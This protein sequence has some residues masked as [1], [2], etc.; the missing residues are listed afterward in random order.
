M[1][2]SVQEIFQIFK[3]KDVVA[4]HLLLCDDV[5]E[6]LVY[7]VETKEKLG[8]YA[9][10]LN[11]YENIVCDEF[12]KYGSWFG[13]DET[14]DEHL[15]SLKHRTHKIKRIVLESY[16]VK[17]ARILTEAPNRIVV[18]VDGP[19]NIEVFEHFLSNLMKVEEIRVE[20]SYYQSE[21][22]KY[23]FLYFK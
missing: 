8:H 11:V 18:T 16:N 17:T 4:Q 12:K 14:L 20:D 3:G 22:L 19:D 9:F 2:K 21:D 7:D 15:E 13:E 5:V 6:V 23:Y 10:G 1:K